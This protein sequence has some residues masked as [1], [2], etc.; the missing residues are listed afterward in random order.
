MLS[1]INRVKA[2]RARFHRADEGSMSV[3]AIISVP[4]V[5]TALIFS[6][7]YFSAFEAKAQAN[8]AAYTLADYVTR[9]TDAVT[10]EFIDGL[11]GIYTFLTRDYDVSVRVS[12]VKWIEEDGDEDSGEYVLQW[13]TAKGDFD[14]LTDDNFAVI[15]GR[16]P[17]MSAGNESIVVETMRYWSAPMIIGLDKVQFYDII[18]SMPRFATHVAFDDSGRG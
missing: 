11:K 12:A 13:S 4:V 5:F 3:E 2:A 10:P 15:E 14:P 1:V 8:K 16:L 17:I 18:S 6:Y 7:C 9:Q